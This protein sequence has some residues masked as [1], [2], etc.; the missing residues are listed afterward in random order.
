MKTLFHGEYAEKIKRVLPMLFNMAELENK[1]GNKISME[2]GSTRERI[3]IGLLCFVFG[4]EAMKFPK[5][6]SHEVDIFVKNIAISIKTKTMLAKKPSLS[7]FSG[8]KLI[9]TVD[10]EK[11]KNFETNYRPSCNMLFINIKWGGMGG[12][13]YIPVE[14]QLKIKNSLG[15]AYMKLPKHGTNPRGIEISKEALSLLLENED[16]LSLKINWQRDKTLL[17]EPALYKRWI[18]LWESL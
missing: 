2:V 9:W 8:V 5:T 3:I 14:T 15:P 6:T 1:R 4:E 18:E 17:K 7:D 11:V 16:T 10:W 13:H 12:F